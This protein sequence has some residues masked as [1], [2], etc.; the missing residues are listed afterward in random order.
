MVKIIKSDEQSQVSVNY[1]SVWKIVLIGILLGL[2][3]WFLTF[4]IDKLIINPALCH[5][6]STSLSCLN[7]IVVSGNI[8]TILIAIIGT[9]IMI[10]SR[11]AQ[12]LII[13][14]TTAATLWGLAQWTSGLSIVEAIIWSIITYVLA[15][16]LYSWITRYDRIF[17]VLVA[18]LLI[19]SIVRIVA[20]L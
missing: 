13:A 16:V 10:L 11:M 3:F 18:I 8:A 14:V 5:S 20:N 1:Y 12:P 19:V 4:L 17:P 15:Y 9:I 6:A 7:S 2:G